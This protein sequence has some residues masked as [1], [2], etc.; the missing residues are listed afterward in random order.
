MTQ[1]PVLPRAKVKIS[2]MLQKYFIEVVSGEVGLNNFFEIP[3]GKIGSSLL[4]WLHHVLKSDWEI[5][6]QRRKG[7]KGMVDWRT[8]GRKK[9]I[10]WEQ[11]HDFVWGL[12]V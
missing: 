10:M 5:K 4:V 1:F 12:Y 11:R 3:F 9:A 7:K 8:Q 2:N 6:D